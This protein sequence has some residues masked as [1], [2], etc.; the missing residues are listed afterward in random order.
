[1]RLVG[2]QPAIGD[3]RRELLDRQRHERLARVEVEDHIGRGRRHE[4]ERLGP[5][6]A[7][8]LV[9]AAAQQDDGGHHGR[10]DR[11]SGEQQRGA[12]AKHRRHASARYPDQP[13]TAR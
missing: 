2:A 13:I 11:E 10:E 7:L 1:V 6:R 3:A 4:G 5:G 9:V 12:A 8:R